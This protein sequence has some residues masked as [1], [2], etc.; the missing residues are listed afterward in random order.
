MND[1][2]QWLQALEGI[3]SITKVDETNYTIVPNRDMAIFLEHNPKD[4]TVRIR[5]VVFEHPRKSDKKS[6]L[7]NQYYSGII[8][9]D[10][11]S[12]PDYDWLGKLI[13][14]SFECGKNINDLPF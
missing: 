9:K 4:F 11:N 13:I 3:E 7:I 12:E 5:F 10:E 2:T 8:P 14:T 6:L 1:L